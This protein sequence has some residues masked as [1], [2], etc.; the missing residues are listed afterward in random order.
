VS[1]QLPH[2][3]D[4]EIPSVHPLTGDLPKDQVLLT[5]EE[6]LNEIV[7]SLE[8][9]SAQEVLTIDL[10]GKS[11][12][13]DYMVIASGRSSRQVTAL[14]EK[15]AQRLKALGEPPR[16]V[17]GTQVGDWVLVDARD[18]IVHLFHPEIRQHYALEKMWGTAASQTRMEPL[19]VDA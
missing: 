14:A 9:D 1:F 7:G 10:R 8:E 15:M 2:D 6:L 19:P 13:A 18:V 12:L 16:S 4:A 11:G 5:S 3:L 17:E